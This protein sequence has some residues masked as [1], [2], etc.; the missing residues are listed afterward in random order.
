MERKKTGAKVSIDNDQL[1][2]ELGRFSS[3]TQIISAASKGLARPLVEQQK[4]ARG[5]DGLRAEARYGV[6]SEQAK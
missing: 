2:K 6:G 3:R 5:F 1:I 4:T